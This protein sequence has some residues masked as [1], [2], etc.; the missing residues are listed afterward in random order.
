[1]EET[2]SDALLEAGE[3]LAEAMRAGLCAQG[4][5]GDVCV[6]VEDGRVVVASR[7]AVVRRSEIGE[8]GSPPQA[9]MEAIARDAG[10]GVVAA[11]AAR[12][13]SSLA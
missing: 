1:M 2:V 7:S 3:R 13:Q 8:P 12:L 11:L 5:P 6:I 4:L 10:P 9:V